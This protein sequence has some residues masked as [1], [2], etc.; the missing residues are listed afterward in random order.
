MRCIRLL[1]VLLFSF[2][3]LHAAIHKETAPLGTYL[4][5]PA[6]AKTVIIDPGHGST[7]LGARTHSPYTEEKRLCLQTA[8]LLKQYLSQLG[9]RVVMTRSTDAFVSLPR[10]VELA[11]QA[12]GDLFVSIHYNSSRVPSAHGVEVFFSDNGEDRTRAAA[13]RRL[14]SSVLQ[15]VIRA[16]DAKSRGVKKGNFYVIRENTMPAILVEGGFLTNPE[17]RDLLRSRDY[18][19]KIARGIAD[20]VD[21]FFRKMKE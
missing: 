11:G 12:S 2:S 7:D 19:E 8:R 16:T 4:T 6:D 17:E 18:Q 15:R 20:G 13:S 14:A 10:R 9:Y 5:V 1:G 21:H 3:A